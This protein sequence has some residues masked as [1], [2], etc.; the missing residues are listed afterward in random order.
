M[1]NKVDNKYAVT[2]EYMLNEDY[3]KTWVINNA[4]LKLLENISDI[5]INPNQPVCLEFEEIHT[6]GENYRFGYMDYTVSVKI[7]TIE[8]IDFK[9]PN[10]IMPEAVAQVNVFDRCKRWL[11]KKL[12]RIL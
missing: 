2:M 1:D 12:R 7:K 8:T 4:K 6:E 9:R 10:N 3:E 5:I 11:K